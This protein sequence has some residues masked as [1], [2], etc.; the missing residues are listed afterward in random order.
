MDSVWTPSRGGCAWELG[1]TVVLSFP[2][3]FVH[4][5]FQP[6]GCTQEYSDPTPGPGSGRGRVPGARGRVKEVVHSRS[7][8]PQSTVHTVTSHEHDIQSCCRCPPG[9]SC[10][11][12]GL[13]CWSGPS[14]RSGRSGSALQSG[15]ERGRHF[16]ASSNHLSM[17]FWWKLCAH[18]RVR[19][20]SPSRISSMQRQHSASPSLSTSRSEHA[21][22]PAPAAPFCFIS[23]L[24]SSLPATLLL[25]P[26]PSLPSR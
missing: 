15:H 12:C 16:C 14:P 3:F 8:P 19:T 26:T 22:E 1:P 25:L 21:S 11:E 5:W 20:T 24:L 13:A 10:P 7:Q 18:G 6:P 4:F 23:D 2:G 9:G 17:H